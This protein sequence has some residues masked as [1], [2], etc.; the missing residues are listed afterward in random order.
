MNS[1]TFR[2]IYRSR[3]FRWIFIILGLIVLAC[4]VAIAWFAPGFAIREAA[5]SGNLGVIKVL[6]ACN[7]RLASNGDAFGQTPLHYAA[8]G[9]QVEAAKLL[10]ANG[11]DVEAKTYLGSTPLDT[12]EATENKD[13]MELLLA[14]H[15]DING[16]DHDGFQQSPLFN[17]VLERHKA[18]AEFLVQHHADV[19]A[20]DYYSRTPLVNAVNNDDKDM[21]ELLLANHADPNAKD[22]EGTTPLHLAVSIAFYQHDKQ[23]IELLLANQADVNAKGKEGTPLGMAIEYS[24]HGDGMKDVVD[25]LRAHGGQE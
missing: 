3:I 11:A 19:N 7:R 18:A 24:K 9:G 12:A 25:L 16:R 10:F 5:S 1:S 21:V 8:A 20:R 4:I 22:K 6:L 23:I 17:A 13:M 2:R 14:N 15:A